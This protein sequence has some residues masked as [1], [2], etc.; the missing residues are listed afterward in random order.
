[1]KERHNAQDDEKG[2]LASKNL[3]KLRFTVRMAQ[4]MGKGLGSGP[5]L[6]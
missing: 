1:V 2:K 5:L 4:E 6:F 3:R